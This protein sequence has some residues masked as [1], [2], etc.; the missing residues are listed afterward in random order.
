MCCASVV[1]TLH[2]RTKAGKA[3]AKEQRSRTRIRN[4]KLWDQRQ[5]RLG[6][7]MNDVVDLTDSCTFVTWVPLEVYQGIL[8]RFAWAMQW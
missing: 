2:A 1:T 3:R 7:K 5:K 8:V 6:A 4:R